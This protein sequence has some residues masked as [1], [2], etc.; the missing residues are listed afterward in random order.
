MKKRDKGAKFW[1]PARGFG[2]SH[3]KTKENKGTMCTKSAQNIA[4]ELYSYL[5]LLPLLAKSQCDSLSFFYG[6]TKECRM[7][8]LPGSEKKKR[9]RLKLLKCR[10]KASDKIFNKMSH[11][12]F[13][14]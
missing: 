2:I 8:L 10:I 5:A 6:N 13:P 3:H 11:T 12:Y 4:D 9:K 14:L 7:L 1:S